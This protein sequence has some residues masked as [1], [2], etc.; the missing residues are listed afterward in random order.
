MIPYSA[1]YRD[2]R[3]NP[4]LLGQVARESGGAVLADPRG[5]FALDRVVSGQP[6]ELWPWLLALA[7]L[8]FVFDVAARRLRLGWMDARRLR[9]G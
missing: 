4:E 8:L 3:A 5:V 2:L 1:E 6:R 7:S 9:L